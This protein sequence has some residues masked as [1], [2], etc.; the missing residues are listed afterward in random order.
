MDAFG[1]LVKKA[2]RFFAS[3]EILGSC[4]TH[5]FFTVGGKVVSLTRRS[6][7]TPPPG[8]FLVLISVRGWV[9]PKAIVRLEGLGKLKISSDLIGTWTRDLPAFS[10][11]LQ[12]TTLSRAPISCKLK[13]WILDLALSPSYFFISVFKWNS[14]WIFRKPAR[15]SLR[16]N[17]LKNLALALP[18]MY[19]IYAW[20]PGD[21]FRESK[22]ITKHTHRDI[23]IDMSLDRPEQILRKL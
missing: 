7:F 11:V 6:L 5:M 19:D 1:F 16:A 23:R 3:K 8:I 15:C 10:I 13:N 21:R 17:Q 22:R 9:D 20:L 18:S 4:G 14:T 2:S 12:P